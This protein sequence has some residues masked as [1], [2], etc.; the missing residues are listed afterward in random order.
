MRLVCRRERGPR[1]C[2]ARSSTF[3][4]TIPVLQQ[5]CRTGRAHAQGQ[6]EDIGLLPHRGADNCC[7]ISSCLDTL[8]KQ[9]HSMLEVLRRACTGDPIMP[10]A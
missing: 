7:T 8:R 6:T 4:D 10:V 5:Y 1:Q 9:V 2:A 3:G